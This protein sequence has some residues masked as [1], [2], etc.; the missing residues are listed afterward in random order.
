MP[1]R[2]T[3]PGAGATQGSPSDRLDDESGAV[4]H[5]RTRRL[6][7]ATAVAAHLIGTGVVLVL[8]VFVLPVPPEFEGW[9][10][11]SAHLVLRNLVA[12]IAYVGLIVP[13][14]VAL[15]LKQAD[16]ATRWLL[17]ER[18]P[19]E[20]EREL[21]LGLGLRLLRMQTGLWAGGVVLFYL[22]NVST[23]GLLA[24]EIAITVAL[25]GVTTVAVAYLLTE[26]NT[27]STIARALAGAPPRS[28]RV[29]GVA[30]RALFAWALG[31]AVPVIGV[32][33]IAAASLALPVS[34]HRVAATALCLDVIALVVG[35]GAMVIFAQSISDP[36]RILRRALADVEAGSLEPRVAVDDGSEVGF[37]Q[38]GFNRMVSG[39][40]ERERLRDLFGRHVGQDVARRAIEEGVMLGGE[41]RD[42]AVLFVDLMDST[43]FAA[44]RGATEV[45]AMLNAF[46]G[47]VVEAT[48]RHG[49][50]VNKFEG[51]AALCIFGVPLELED[52]AGGALTAGRE[53]QAR[54]V[55]DLPEIRAAI[56][57]SAGTVVAGNVGAA[58]RF[59]YTV[60]G[61][62]VNEAA[63][64]AE[65]AMDHPGRIVA[66]ETIVARAGI[67]ESARWQLA[68]AVLL[69]GRTRPTRL[70]MP[71]AGAAG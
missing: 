55:C 70:A 38:A 61:D 34:A 44:D 68:E 57:L 43:S 19:T 32:V 50:F 15:G 31:T 6:T 53:M 56:G 12:A 5:R 21:A 16:P 9:T 30:T 62:A 17:E 59:E 20:R 8:L 45:V 52:A 40:R 29:P 25:G 7:V 71:A 3:G 64:L 27:R 41:E 24:F 22:L 13:A 36:L 46:F 14:G 49:G 33:A 2:K 65:L 63:R 51:D 23:S 48:R 60:I 26:R 42:A 37:L 47:I 10:P 69:R 54:L 39:L 67:G 18:A 28:Y 58:D 1:T 11:A 35:L 66:S 4:V